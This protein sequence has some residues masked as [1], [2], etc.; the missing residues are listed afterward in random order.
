TPGS[1]CYTARAGA[2]AASSAPRPRTGE[3][4]SQRARQPPGKDAMD[5]AFTA[6]E[7]QFRDELR[8]FLGGEL[9]A[10]WGRRA[11]I[12]DL[13]PDEHEELAR[14]VT[15]A[16]ADRRWLAMPWAEQYGGLSASHMQQAIYNEETSYQRM[17]GGGG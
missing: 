5:F 3:R 9:P 15:K 4:S 8:R 7:E 10:D 12:G 13:D 1:A 14:R 16:L 17:P 2:D 6:G 11:F